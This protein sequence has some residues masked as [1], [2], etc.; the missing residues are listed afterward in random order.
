MLSDENQIHGYQRRRSYDRVI[1]GFLATLQHSLTLTWPLFDFRN[2][3]HIFRHIT[4]RVINTICCYEKTCSTTGFIYSHTGLK[5]LRSPGHR[6]VSLGKPIRSQDKHSDSFDN[7]RQHCCTI[8]ISAQ[9][10][11]SNLGGSFSVI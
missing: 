11:A 1:L 3:A 6:F 5:F 4:L 7:K 8:A 10:S 2:Y 9:T